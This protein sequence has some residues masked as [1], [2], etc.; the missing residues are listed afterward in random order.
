MAKETA[1]TQFIGVDVS[2]R[3]TALNLA[4][5]AAVDMTGWSLSFMVKKS[6][7]H[8]DADAKFSRTTSAGITISGTY[9]SDPAVNTQVAT[10]SVED[11]HTDALTPGTYYYELK[12]TGAGVEAVIAY[13]TFTLERGVHRT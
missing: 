7:G 8:L 1:I 9:N 5:T 6:K 13:G 10:V 4:E 3:F 12:R 11:S 2:Y